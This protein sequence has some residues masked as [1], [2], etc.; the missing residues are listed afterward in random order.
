MFEREAERW[1][2]F[3]LHEMYCAGHLFQ[4]AVAHH[5]V[6]GKTTLLDVAIRFADCI[7]ARFGPEAE[8]KQFGL[9]GHPEI[10]MAL[11]ELYRVTHDEKYLK[12]VRYFIAVRGSGRLQKPF[13]AQN[14]AYYQDRVP[15]IELTR[16]EGHAVRAVYLNCGAADMIAEAADPAVY[17]ALEQMWQ[18]MTTRQMY[19]H[20]GLG[21]R[22][23]TEGMGQDYELPNS[24][25]YAETCAS[26]ANL[27]WNWRMLMLEGDARYAD[28]I[29]WTLYNSVLSGVSL[30]GGA[31]FY[32]NPL[33][34]NGQHRREEWFTVSCCPGNIA[35]L[36]AMLPG[37]LYSTSAQ[38][39]WVH[40]YASST[41]ATS[42]PD[43]KLV[44]WAIRTDYPWSGE[45]TLQPL[46]G[47]EHA[48]AIR[49]P[50][51][52]G[53]GWRIDL[54]GQPA[55]GELKHGYWHLHRAWQP[56]DTL[57]VH[58]PMPV[59]LVETHPFA[60]EN[61]GRVALMRGPLLYCIEAVDHRTGDVRLM[62][63]VDGM[64]LTATF[65]QELLGGVVI[66]QGE[67]RIATA[68]ENWGDV[69][70]QSKS[71]AASD[72]TGHM[73]PLTAIP[74]YA[75]ANRAV[76]SMQVWLPLVHH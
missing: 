42:L 48:L 72:N 36:L 68:M 2:N 37:Y 57:T 3:D 34:D 59:R 73:V 61:Q 53:D 9:D 25:A 54:N 20:G 51:W 52:A 18:T 10:E 17:A 70:Y 67:A 14:S 39:L 1:T 40:L 75:W 56:G 35:R 46:S 43:G 62:Q 31:Y 47:N 63:L 28:L 33:N 71:V 74:Y 8:G 50:A 12:Q 30:D 24:R 15:F 49:I 26:V 44:E 22:Y 27:M 13:S 60:V 32:Q 19:V 16:L 69:L 4:A 76:G 21:S 23:E 64:A 41:V 45:I 6:T 29:E 38:T 11:V 5:R 66:I 58:L 7:C 55:P 65:N